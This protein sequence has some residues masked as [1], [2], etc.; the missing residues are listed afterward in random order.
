MS[1][2]Q[3]R[4]RGRPSRTLAALLI[5]CAALLHLTAQELSLPNAPDSVKFAV[6]GDMGT[7]EQEQYDVA[8]QMTRFHAK[9]AFG[10]VITLGDNIYGGQGPADL[11]KKFSQPYKPLLDAGVRF[12][13]ALGNHDDPANVAYPLWNMGGQR[14]YTYV[15][16]NVAFF[17]LDSDQLDP[18]QV[19]WITNALKT[20][21]SAWKICYFHHPLYSDGRTHGSSVDLR[22]VLEPIFV[23]NGVNVVLSGHDHIYERITPQKGI[24]YFVSGAAGQL[25]K[26]DTERSAMTAA[27]FDQ[28]RSFM[29]VE[30]AANDLAFQVISRT[31]VTV[32]KGTIHR[33]AKPLEKDLP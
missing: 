1:T 28:D 11:V 3:E 19:D 18:K 21:R 2:D 29:L 33:Q 23:A 20:S 10:H 22:V 31:G 8:Q 24:T 5:V 26:G 7:G 14:Y 32:D 9:F 6:I 27:S 4:H 16:K 12:Y 15:V 25:R 17:V 30:I 13:A